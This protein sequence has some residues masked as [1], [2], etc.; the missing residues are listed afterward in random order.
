MGSVCSAE[1]DCIEEA[2][3]T[4]AADKAYCAVSWV[5]AMCLKPL[6]VQQNGYGG[7]ELNREGQLRGI[8][9]TDT[10]YSSM[11]GSGARSKAKQVLQ[12]SSCLCALL[13]CSAALGILSMLPGALLATLR[14]QDLRLQS[15][16][17]KAVLGYLLPA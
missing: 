13:H 8:R 15:Q 10:A 2:R 1:L 3:H 14:Q 17:F 11:D 6:C 4:R 12:A 5:Q 7:K 9:R 16:S